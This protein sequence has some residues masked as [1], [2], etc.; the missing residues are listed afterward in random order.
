MRFSMLFL[1]LLPLAEIATFVVVGKM[2]GLGAV[3]GLTIAGT[4]A[5]VYVLRVKGADALRRLAAESREGR[6]AGRDLVH[7]ALMVIGALLLI[8]PGFLTDALGLLL[9]VPFVRDLAWSRF[10]P[11]IVM[12]SRGFSS[13]GPRRSSPYEPQAN[14]G[15]EPRDVARPHKPGGDDQVIDLDPQDFQRG[16]GQR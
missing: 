4:F 12:A 1:A 9:L 3:L 16:D 5:G 14:A 6:D 10:R 13:A 2:L 8:L 7:T 15:F 11:R